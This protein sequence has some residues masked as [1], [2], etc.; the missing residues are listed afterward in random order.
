[1]VISSE[2]HPHSG[3]D[4]HSLLTQDDLYLFKWVFVLSPTEFIFGMEVS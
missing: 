3:E 1:M 4:V 2:A